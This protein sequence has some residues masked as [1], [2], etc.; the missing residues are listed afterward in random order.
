MNRKKHLCEQLSH[1]LVATVEE[2]K[3]N[4]QLYLGFK[5]YQDEISSRQQFKNYQDSKA[6]IIIQDEEDDPSLKMINWG[7]HFWRLLKSQAII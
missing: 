7:C 1:P 3:S 4:L 6:Q 5:T 2:A